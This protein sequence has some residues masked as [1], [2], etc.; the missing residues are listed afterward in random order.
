M[1]INYKPDRILILRKYIENPVTKDVISAFPE[2]KVEYV[3]KQDIRL[4]GELGEIV[5]QGQR[6][7][8][9]GETQNFISPSEGQKIFYCPG[10]RKITP[11]T[12][13]PFRCTYC[14][15]QGTFR[16]AHPRKK[17]N[18][19]T[20]R[21][22]KQ[23]DRDIEKRSAAGITQVY[24]MGELQDSLAFDYIFPLTK[25]L[26]PYFAE[27]DARLMLLT[28][29]D[30]VDNLLSLEHKRHT[31]VSWSINSD[32]VTKNVEHDSATLDERIS[33]AKKVQKAGYPIRF[34]FDPLLRIPGRKWKRDYQGMLNKVF[35]ELKPE[36]VT[37]G[38]LRYHPIIKAISDQRFH[39]NLFK[40]QGISD[41][42]NTDHRYRYE[43]KKRLEMYQYVVDGIKKRS[44]CEI[45]LCKETEEVW[46]A[47]GLNFQRSPPKC[48]C[49]L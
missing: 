40:N 14:F 30:C 4:K 26:V 2:A 17:F 19:N 47:L 21:L 1:G 15:L 42:M 33:A 35:A 37:L 12:G 28:K 41:N 16:A 44:D 29:S 36:R 34:R 31:I 39:S 13:C 24:H 43:D 7:I 3:D 27:K 22:I 6:I 49:Y 32:Y 10:P 9:L 18:L 38:S 45:A 48:H 11:I 23:L 25:L 8:L 20:D 46:K 5:E